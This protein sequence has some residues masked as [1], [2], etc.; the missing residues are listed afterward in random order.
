[1]SLTNDGKIR[2]NASFT[3]I[4]D[5]RI[6]KDIVDIDDNVGLEKM[7]LVQPKTYKYIDEEKG[8]H[9]V[10]GFIAQQIRE[11]IP[12]AVDLGEGKLP[13]GDEVEDFNCLNKSY[14]FT[15]NVCAT[16]EL[17]RMIVRQQEVID[18]LISRIDVLES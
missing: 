7:L 2:A 5:T 1:M 10:I 11:I 18:N 9:T 3:N 17:H 13:N 16:Q 8:T 4:S 14:I 15:L 12:E 6:K